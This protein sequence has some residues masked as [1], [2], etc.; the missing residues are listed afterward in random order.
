MANS[1]DFYNDTTQT[2]DT[3][4]DANH[5]SIDSMT[6]GYSVAGINRYLEAVKTAVLTDVCN[7]LEDD[8]EGVQNIKRAFDKGW[9]GTAREKFDLKF[10]KARADIKAEIEKEYNDFEYRI[11]ELRD[12]FIKQDNE[13]MD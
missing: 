8:F 3:V 13:M 2:I 5:L 10:Q 7:M 6:M 4:Q 12:N 1:W 9:I 11:N